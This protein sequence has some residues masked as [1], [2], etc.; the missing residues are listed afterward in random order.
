[1]TDPKKSKAW[2][3]DKALEYEQKVENKLIKG[4]KYDKSI[5]LSRKA[6]EQGYNAIKFPS[7]RGAEGATNMVIYHTDKVPVNNVLSPEMIMPATK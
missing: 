6:R 4:Y 2:E 1:M 3:Y 5:E 7:K